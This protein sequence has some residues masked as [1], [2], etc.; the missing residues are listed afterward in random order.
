[1]KIHSDMLIK[2]WE[3]G[4]LYILIGTIIFAIYSLTTNVGVVDW[5]KELT[6]FNY[7]KTSLE[8][9]HML[10]YFWWDKLENVAWY[11]PILVTASFIAIP[12]TPLFTP[13]IPLII[14]MS[15]IHFAKLYIFL[16]FLVG[17][18]GVYKL[19]NKLKWNNLQFRTFSA[20]FLFSPIIMQ[21][22]AVG[23]SPW[24]NI[25]LFP[26]FVYFLS[27]KRFWRSSVGLSGTMAL[28]L[29]QGG[30]YTF[31]WFATIL[32]LYSIIKY[33][34]DKDY[35]QLLRIISVPLL[36]IVLALVRIYS[37]SYAYSGFSREWFLTTGYN[38]FTFF[39]YALTPTLI[40]EP[41]DILFYRNVPGL[42]PGFPPHDAGLFWGL[43][44]IMLIF[45]IVRNKK[46][47]N[48]TALSQDEPINNKA[49]LITSI[50]IL[51]FSFYSI[52]ALFTK[53]INNYLYL[54]FYESIKNY[55]FRFAVPAYLG[56]TVVLAYNVDKIWDIMQDFTLTNFWI[57]IKLFFKNSAR[58]LFVFLIVLLIALFMFES[59]LLT[60]FKNI[61][62][63]AY[64]GESFSFLSDRMEGMS[65]N[66][67]EFYLI[68]AENMYGSIQ[69]WVL[70]LFGLWIF[71]FLI[72]H[73]LNAIKK[74]NKNFINQYPYI[75]FEMLL[76]IPLL[77]SIS[78]W[79]KLATSVPYTDFPVQ[80]VN[81]PTVEIDTQSNQALPEI[82]VT[83]K[84]MTVY[85]K[86]NVL[87]RGYSFPQILARD[88]KYLEVESNNAVFFDKDES[89]KIIPID[90]KNI[91]VTFNAKYIN[92]TLFITIVA[93]ILLI[94][95]FIIVNRKTD[96]LN[97]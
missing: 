58:I 15:A 91:V 39:A 29:L 36:A 34:Y 86:A 5:Q 75:K 77:F 76:V 31:I 94:L 87:S 57:R 59:R 82:V 88:Y 80:S 19:K 4:Y 7:I 41:F 13:L 69:N 89:L 74:R 24:I 90:D 33:F 28:V 43:S 22:L 67:L 3:K 53:T 16:M 81:Q 66:T 51:T 60:L 9:Y 18:F 20:M 12:E 45:V 14:M 46:I 73:L 83:P 32:G 49:L 78:M 68:K 17:A 93:W 95:F 79:T 65:L 62:E 48:S 56:V 71:S 37:T 72:I 23:Y 25:F 10:P 27:E 30:I 97:V 50:I 96:R 61:V 63:K 21:H 42:Y 47:F 35:V 55:G 8:D 6:Y 44:V 92:L 54:P 70:V 11:P 38:P 52:W 1:M 84:Q 85:Q 26:W 40:I 64:S 2:T